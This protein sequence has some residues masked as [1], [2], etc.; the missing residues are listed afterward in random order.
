MMLGY[1][2]KKLTDGFEKN[3]GALNDTFFSYKASYFRDGRHY[4]QTGSGR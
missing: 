4:M 3:G 2:L 1:V